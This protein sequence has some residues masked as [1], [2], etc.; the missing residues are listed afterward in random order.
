MDEDLFILSGVDEVGVEGGGSEDVD[1]S[2]KEV[3]NFL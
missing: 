2:I 1:R 3:F